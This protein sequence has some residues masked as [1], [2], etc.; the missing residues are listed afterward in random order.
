MVSLFESPLLR[1]QVGCVLT[2]LL[3]C[4]G[5]GLRLRNLSIE[6]GRSPDEN[7]YTAQAQRLLR[8]GGAGLRGMAR[9][10]I[11]DPAARLAGPPTRAGYLWALAGVM[12]FTGRAD[13][14]AGALLSTAASIGSLLLVALI[15]I[16]FFPPWA[17]L[18]AMLLFA[19]N[20]AEQELARRQWADAL[21]GMLGLLLVY[22]AAEITR[23]ST[24]RRWHAAFVLVGSFGMAVKEFGPIIFSLSAVWVLWVMAVERRQY[25]DAAW[26]AAGGALG[27]LGV[28]GWLAYSV[29]GVAT[30]WQVVADWRGA[31]VGNL[32]AQEFQAGPPSYLLRAIYINSPLTAALLL[33]ALAAIALTYWNKGQNNHVEQAEYGPDVWPRMT[34]FAAS[35]LALPMFLPNWLNLRYIS[36]LFGPFALLAGLGSW[37]MHQ[38]IAAIASRW[39]GR[40]VACAAG[41]ILIV[42]A[43]SDARRFERFYVN[44]GVGDL[45]VKLILDRADMFAAEKRVRREASAENYLT[46]CWR[47]EQNWRN[48]D[49]IAACESALRLRPGYAEAYDQLAVA[50]VALEQWDEAHAAARRAL[51]LDGTLPRA[52]FNLERAQREL[53]AVVSQ[54]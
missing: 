14:T 5:I 11:A 51:A 20:P 37:W 9:E 18:P 3:L 16:R 22:I 39:A 42:S 45:S 46:L 32:Y 53:A 44:D 23:D 19:V 21:V 47:Y 13:A 54:R 40:F 29:G 10:Y 12:R 7:N 6:T 17:A 38:L 41:V 33:A 50:H 28:L 27:A 35:F 31:H 30:L 43:V 48:R 2:T 36:V 52:K 15:G 26:L 4:L 49:S 24:R 8:E 1:T 25:R 34:L